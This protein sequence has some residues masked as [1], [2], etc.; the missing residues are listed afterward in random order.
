MLPVCDTVIPEELQ[1]RFCI[2]ST[3]ELFHKMF[4]YVYFEKSKLLLRQFLLLGEQHEPQSLF[5][6]VSTHSVGS[7]VFELKLSDS[8]TQNYNN[9]KSD[10]V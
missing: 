1:N 6:C 7:K 8:N 5:I 10:E 4:G 9:T 2:D 3:W